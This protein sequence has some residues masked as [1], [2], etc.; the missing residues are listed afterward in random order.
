MVRPVKDKHSS[1]DEDNDDA[2]LKNMQAR[3]DADTIT[4]ILVYN[5]MH[6]FVVATSLGQ[7]IVFKWDFAN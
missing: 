4:D 2:F 7:L 3:S 1:D 6:Y 5:P